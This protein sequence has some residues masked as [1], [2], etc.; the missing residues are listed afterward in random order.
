MK[1]Y[2]GLIPP[3]RVKILGQQLVGVIEVVGKDVKLFKNGY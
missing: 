1:L 3:T 2:F